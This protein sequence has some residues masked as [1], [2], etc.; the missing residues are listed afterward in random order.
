RPVGISKSAQ[1]DTQTDTNAQPD[2]DTQKDSNPQAASKVKSVT[3]AAL[4]LTWKPAQTAQSTQI[5]RVGNLSSRSW[6]SVVGWNPGNPEIQPE[7]SGPR[8]EGWPILS[9]GHDPWM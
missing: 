8:L 2:T 1:S 9:I 6:A 4:P 3:F 5:N 7:L